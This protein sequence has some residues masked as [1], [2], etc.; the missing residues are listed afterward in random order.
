M[1]QRSQPLEPE[2]LKTRIVEAAGR[3]FAEEGYEALSMRRV[4]QEVGC[5][6]MAMYRHFANKEALIQHICTELYTR[7]AKQMATEMDAEDDP[8]DKLRRFIRALLQFAE[9]FPDH[10]S[11]IFLVRH[12]DPE[13]LA[14]REQLGQQFLAH[15]G[16][17]VRM[18]M[19]PGST[20][21]RANQVLRRMMECIHGTTALL[22]AHPHAYG[23]TRQKA[24]EDVEA[25]WHLLL[26]R[27]AA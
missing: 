1:K 19:P 9:K 20:L 5:S 17:V 18:A 11:L 26:T 24:A 13:V 23:I 27:Q 15:V 25:M 22:L 12:S 10:Y 6:Q 8:W 3:L 16:K 21:H 7:F 4:A 2:S 14:M